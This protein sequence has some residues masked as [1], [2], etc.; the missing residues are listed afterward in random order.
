VFLHELAHSALVW[1]GRGSFNS[2]KLGGIEEAGEYYEKAVFG[3][4]SSCEITK[5]DFEITKVGFYKG[6]LFYPIGKF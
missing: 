2:P 1:Y 6:P 5:K 4:V 3:G